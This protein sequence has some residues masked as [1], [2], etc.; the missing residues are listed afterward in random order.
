MCEKICKTSTKAAFRFPDFL[1]D[2]RSNNLSQGIN[3]S[4]KQWKKMFSEKKGLVGQVLN[5][6]SRDQYSFPDSITYSLYN[7]EQD[8]VSASHLQ[9]K[10][11]AI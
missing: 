1:T 2:L 5:L 11:N 8:C 9:R 4:Q 6:S 7:T 10:D 3:K